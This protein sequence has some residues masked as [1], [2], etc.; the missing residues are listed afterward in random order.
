MT[1]AIN[2]PY[3]ID[4]SGVVGSTS[5]PPKIYLD[6]VLTLLSTSIGQRPMLPTY[7]VDWSTALFENDNIAQPAISSAIRTAIAK[8]LPEV[9][10]NSI[11]F[12]LNTRNGIEL[13][14]LGLTLP[15]IT[16]T[17]LTVNTN[18]LNYDGT[19]AG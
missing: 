13:V 5:N 3:T 1:L 19:I 7:G 15:D 18:Q 9:K 11:S 4:A 14:T 8:W 12:G 2:Y 17:S 6:R 10:V 16:V